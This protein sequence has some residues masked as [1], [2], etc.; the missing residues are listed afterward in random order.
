MGSIWIFLGVQ[1]ITGLFYPFTIVQQLQIIRAGTFGAIF[2]YLFFANHL[3]GAVQQ[4]EMDA[5]TFAS[6]GFVLVAA[7]SALFSLLLWYLQK[8]W[9]FGR[10]HH[11]LVIGAVSLLTL[12]C[13]PVLVAWRIMLPGI[14]IDPRHTPWVE[15][16]LWAKQNTRKEAIFLTP[17]NHLNPVEPDWRVL[18]E[19]QSLAS[20]SDLLEVALA[21]EYLPIWR[22][23]FE[24]LAPGAIS[25]F[26]GNYFDS[27]RI[28]GEAYDSLSDQQLLDAACKYR[29]SFAVV[30]KPRR[31]DLPVVHENEGFVVYDLAAGR[32]CSHAGSGRSGDVATSY[33]SWRNRRAA[34]SSVSSRLAKQNLM[35]RS[36]VPS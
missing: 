13:V 1:L 14:Y 18:S 36:S 30:Q 6:Q 21:P 28:A 32:P 11:R 10:A 29:A 2:G 27:I 25:K 33:A 24:T 34:S 22:E 8:R 31:R 26:N 3:V 7:P 5:R 23:R 17:P 19:R 15:T 9:A 12:A 20:L 4:Q 35:T 16:Q